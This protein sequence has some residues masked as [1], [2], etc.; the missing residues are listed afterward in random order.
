MVQALVGSVLIA[1]LAY[2]SGSLVPGMIAHTI[3]DIFNFSYWWT[4]VAGKFDRRPIA[5]TGWDAHALIW[6]LILVTALAAY[7]WI[8]RRL[9][10]IRLQRRA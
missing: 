8:I 10:A 3:M 6:I 4:D 1:V 9:V 5:E 7:L 2:A